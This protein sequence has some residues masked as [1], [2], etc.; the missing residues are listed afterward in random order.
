MLKI[1][2]KT[3]IWFSISLTIIVIGIVALFV[4]GLQ[5]GIDFKGGALMEVDFGKTVN[6]TEVRT[7]INKYTKISAKT[8]IENFS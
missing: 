4:N 7:I 3:K 5:L 1:I 8:L 2:E 6:Q